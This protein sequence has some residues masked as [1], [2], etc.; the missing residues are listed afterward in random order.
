MPNHVKNILNFYGKSEDV[1][2]LFD[3]IAGT[4][5]EGKEVAI[6]FNNII[7]V[8][9]EIKNGEI[10]DKLSWCTNR[11]GTKWNAYEIECVNDSTITFW[12]AWGPPSKVIKKLSELFP[13]ITI[14]HEWADED[15]GLNCGY[16]RYC[17]GEEEFEAELSPKEAMEHSASIW[18]YDLD[19]L[20][21]YLNFTESDYIYLTDSYDEYD[22]I[23]IM[24]QKGLFINEILRKSELPK[25]VFP[26]YLMSGEGGDCIATLVYDD[27]WEA[28]K[29]TILTKEP[30][31]KRPYPF[32]TVEEEIILTVDDF[33]EFL[34][35][36]ENILKFMQ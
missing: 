12:T 1:E 9:E 18:G 26:Y 22:V 10:V 15:I 35:K 30:L 7:P 27:D 11:W 17:A 23:S 28:A 36:K 21:Y 13:D 2:K 19:E 31:D 14:S 24:G 33:P 8:P 20:G 3:F 34:G 25:G 4:N 29:A 16:I 6:T 5:D 32:D